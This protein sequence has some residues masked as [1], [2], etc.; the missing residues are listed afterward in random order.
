MSKKESQHRKV[1]QFLNQLK[2]REIDEYINNE[3]KENH[4]EIIEILW[5][6]YRLFCQD[7]FKT[8]DFDSMSAPDFMV[9]LSSKTIIWEKWQ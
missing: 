4:N 2:P 8:R 5:E 1:L 9:W 3:Y 7:A 6:K